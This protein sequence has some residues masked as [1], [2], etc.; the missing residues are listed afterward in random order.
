MRKM[1]FAMLLV[2]CAAMVGC[3]TV[4]SSG[5]SAELK[6]HPDL[7]AKAGLK[8]YW[9]VKVPL[10][11]GET[12]HSIY[13]LDEN[14]Y[15]MT[16]LNRIYAM[17]AATGKF[18]WA[19][20]LAKQS[21]TVF[22]PVNVDG[23]ALSPG[24]YGI[25]E[26]L[27]PEKAPPTI[28]SDAVVITVDTYALV[29]NRSTGQAI[30]KYGDIKFD[31]AAAGSAAS[32]G[33]YLYV[34]GAEG[35]YY[36]I[37]L[38]TALTKWTMTCSYTDRRPVT[39]PIKY[40][41]GRIYVANQTGELFATNVPVQHNVDWTVALEGSITGDMVVDARGCFVPCWDN[42]IYA[43]ECNTGKPLW[44]PFICDGSLRQGL[45]AGESTLFAGSQKNTLYAL[46]I[47]TGQQR[48]TLAGGKT[49]MGVFGGN[50]YVQTAKNDLVVI[51]EMLGTKMV[52]LPMVGMD[53]AAANTTS[54]AV[55][56]G[57]ATGNLYCI[58]PADTMLLTEETFHPKKLK[59]GRTTRPASAPA[60]APAAAAPAAEPAAP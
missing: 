45:Q 37:N 40:Y 52:S 53:L 35:N 58:T 50:V 44:E 29:F 56:V 10:T 51:D 33:A 30:R 13:R 8:Y 55:F 16:D 4:G 24:I 20:E 54:R 14:V 34:G 27:S 48:W 11:D 18:K 31:F 36:A 32:D 41:N 15:C 60:S 1:K 5:T 23:M 2:I 25:D 21:A 42:R 17:D 46:N 39:S 38:Q 49:V 7:L 12:I 6:T 47:A 43:Y 9:D 19:A 28:M 3:G 59:T 22:P 26:V 57:T